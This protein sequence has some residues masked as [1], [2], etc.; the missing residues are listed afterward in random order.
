M[1]LVYFVVIR[2]SRDCEDMNHESHETHENRNGQGGNYAFYSTAKSTTPGSSSAA[3]SHFPFDRIFND[4]FSFSIQFLLIA[5]NPVMIG[6]LP[7]ETGMAC[8]FP[9]GLAM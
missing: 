6:L 2:D 9:A 1:F 8:L 4:V 3:L 7:S 5:D